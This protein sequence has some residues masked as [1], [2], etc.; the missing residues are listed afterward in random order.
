[1]N[2]KITMTAPTPAVL[3]GQIFVPQKNFLVYGSGDVTS[4]RAQSILDC[5]Q[6]YNPVKAKL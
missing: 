6:I 2:I 4:M 1:M 5:P 3:C